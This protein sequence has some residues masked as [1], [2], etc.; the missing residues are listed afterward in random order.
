MTTSMKY[1]C[2]GIIY[3]LPKALAKGMLIEIHWEA[4]RIEL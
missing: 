1:C 4:Y 3:A 2:Y